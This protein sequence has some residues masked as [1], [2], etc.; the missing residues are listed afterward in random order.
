MPDTFSRWGF[1]H[2]LVEHELA[3]DGKSVVAL[4]SKTRNGITHYE[5]VRARF[6]KAR[7]V[8]GVRYPSG[9][10]LPSSERWGRDGFS[11]RRAEEAKNRYDKLLHG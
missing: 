3:P 10:K 7:D 9:F 8:N 11:F 2:A 4:Y 1:S 6:R 5:V